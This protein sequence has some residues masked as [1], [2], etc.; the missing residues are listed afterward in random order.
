MGNIIPGLYYIAHD[1]AKILQKCRSFDKIVNSVG[2]QCPTHSPITVKFRMSEQSHNVL[3]HTKFYHHWHTLWHNHQRSAGIPV[4]AGIPGLT[5][6]H[7]YGSGRCFTG[8]GIPAFTRKKSSQITQLLISFAVTVWWKFDKVYL[9]NEFKGVL[10]SR[11]INI[12]PGIQRTRQFEIEQRGT[13]TRQSTTWH[14]RNVGITGEQSTQRSTKKEAQSSVVFWQ[15][16][17]PWPRNWRSHEFCHSSWWNRCLFDAYSTTNFYLEDG[18]D[19]PLAFWKLHRT[20][21]PKLAVITRS[22][23]S[24]PASQNK[25][26]RAFSAAG[27]DWPENDLRSRAFGRTIASQII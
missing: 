27:H 26:E 12:A 15:R 17:W 14:E 9:F 23:Y 20:R 2:F 3:Y 13:R 24:I 7:G 8:T 16:W 6:T 5:C 25:S 19:A 22:V 4:P 21:F 1:G 18:N 11:V 10:V